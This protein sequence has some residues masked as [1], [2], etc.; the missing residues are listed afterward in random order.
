MLVRAIPPLAI[1]SNVPGFSSGRSPGAPGEP[2]TRKAGAATAYNTR[3]A[4]NVYLRISLAI[5]SGLAALGLAFAAVLFGGYYYVE[6][7]LPLAEELRDIR[8]QIPMRVY[9]RDGRLMQ[10][11]GEQKRT[12]VPYEDVPEI[13]VTAVL[14]AED[15]RFFEHP[16]LDWA[17]TA[18]AAFEFVRA[19]MGGER[20]PGGSTITQ[21]VAREYFLTREYQLVRKFKELILALRIERE[22]SKQEILELFFNTTFFGQG[23]YGVVAAARTYFDKRLDEI[24]LSDAAILAGIPQGPSIMNPV[25]SPRNAAGRR[26]YVLG[27]LLELGE[28]SRPEYDRALAVPI[29]SRRYGQET[30]LDAPYL[31]EMARVEVIR[32]F[33]DIAYEAGLK[34]TTTV[35]SRLQRAANAAMRDALIAY[36]ERHGYRGSVARVSLPDGAGDIAD[37]ASYWADLLADYSDAAGFE[38]GLVLGADEIEALVYVRGQGYQTIGLE[39]VAWA[40]RFITDNAVGAR[41]DAVDDVLSTGEIVRLRRTDDGALRLSQLPDVQGAFVSLDPKDGAVTALVGGFDFFLSNFNR[42]TQSLRQPGSAFKPF[43]YSAALQDG[44]ST[45]TIVNDAPFV[46][47]DPVLETVWKPENFGSEFHGEVQLREALIRSYNAATVRVMAEVGVEDTVHHLRKFGFDDVALPRNLS[48]SL[49]TG[50]VS[51]LNLA[52]GYAILANGGYGVAPYFIERIEDESGNLLY[53]AEPRV[54]CIDFSVPRQS[55][56]AEFHTPLEPPACDEPH[57]VAAKP[58]GGEPAVNEAAALI[59][60]DTRRAERVVSAP[61]VYLVT[62]MM[63]DVIRRG[64][65]NRAQRELGR[66][67]L[68]GKTGTTNDLRDAWF[69]GFNGDVVATAWVGFDADRPLGGNEQ[70][71]FTAIPAWIGFMAEALDGQP[72]HSLE[73]PIGIVDVRINPANGLVASDLTRN[74]VFEKFRID[75]IPEREPDPILADA[76]ADEVPGRQVATP[77]RIF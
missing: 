57:A 73:R 18:K 21:Q 46:F 19:G 75:N 52:N 53:S 71:G 37:G 38:L 50:G 36:D 62:D 10:Q 7:S 60:P 69:S 33:G 45:A 55:D 28:I 39:A 65:G 35:D 16:G 77:E 13:L 26:A 15:D 63:R 43:I 1:L 67:D 30:R 51:P 9:S 44:Y 22:F 20:V 42:A 68:A 32:R 47:E 64:T 58:D 25:Y 8:L 49:G 72:P 31:A 76:P 34:V 17:H 11:F 2:A 12:P 56:D 41:P 54:A 3:L 48:L 61:N 74:A 5:S 59:Y 40:A 24:T 27:R 70:G 14:A 66:T 6:P 23:S 29:V 4:M